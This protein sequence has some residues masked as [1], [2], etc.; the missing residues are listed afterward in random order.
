MAKGNIS[1]LDR[2][3][4]LAPLDDPHK[5]PVR[6][7]L[8]LRN[9]LRDARQST[10]LPFYRIA[11]QAGVDR[12]LLSMLLHG[13]VVGSGDARLARIGRWVSARTGLPE[14]VWEEPA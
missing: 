5:E 3:S 14:G 6:M 1:T 8:C 4:P 9:A 11:A 2:T 7:S 12:S 10:G 13:K